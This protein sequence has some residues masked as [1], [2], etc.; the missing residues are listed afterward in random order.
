MSEWRDLTE[1]LVKL[2]FAIE[3]LDA[4]ASASEDVEQLARLEA[5]RD[6]L[7]AAIAEHHVSRRVRHLLEEDGARV[8]SAAI[9]PRD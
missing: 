3:D 1:R 2:D 8:G 5:L 4:W 6:E 9:D 7:Q